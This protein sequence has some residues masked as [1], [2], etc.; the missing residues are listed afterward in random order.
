M[1]N[2]LQTALKCGFLNSTG[3]KLDVALQ[4][5]KGLLAIHCHGE[6]AVHGNLKDTNIL[7]SSTKKVFITDWAISR[8]LESEMSSEDII[9]RQNNL[10]FTAPEFYGI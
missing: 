1:K 10:G 9:E 3:Q 7:I 4:I 2:N 6:F 8:F 5:A